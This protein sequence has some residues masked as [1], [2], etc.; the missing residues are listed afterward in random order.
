M[1]IHHTHKAGA[2]ERAMK[3]EK[4]EAARREKV[5]ARKAAKEAA[6]KEKAMQDLLG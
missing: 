2:G 6:A 3:K 4:K 1:G 5:L